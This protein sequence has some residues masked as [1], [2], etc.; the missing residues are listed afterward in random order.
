M[1]R[2]STSTCR[3]QRTR[4]SFGS[5]RAGGASPATVRTYTERTARSAAL[6]SA[7]GLHGRP[8]LARLRRAV[9]RRLF[10]LHYQPIVALE[11][12]R[13]CHHEALLRL[14]D[15]PEEGLIAPS[16]FLPAAER[17]GLIREIDRMVIAEAVA[18][19]ASAG[20]AVP[21]R[22]VAVNLSALSVAA[23]GTLAHMERV[24]ERHGVQPSRLIVEITETAAITDMRR[25]QRFC[26]EVRS[27][28]CSIALDDFGAGFNS[29]LYLKRLAFDYLKIDGDFVRALPRSHKDQ[30]VV[31][32]LV[33]LA[34]GLGKRTIAEHVTGPETV[35]L[36]REYGVDYGQ[37][38][39]L[40][41]PAA[42]VEIFAAAA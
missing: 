6:A 3:G 2:R 18:L 20:T 27:L 15:S 14:A 37:G 21:A 1:Q 36:L 28:G 34:Q 17:Y 31:Q 39:G 11:D 13:V 22:P 12:G 30:L 41:R 7:A 29:F 16:S 42:P 23:D 19:M 40:G 10:V 25:A 5:V 9:Q 24:F 26:R 8:W 4:V 38:F 35:D 33:R 32:A